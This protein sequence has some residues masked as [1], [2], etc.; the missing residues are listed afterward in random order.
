MIG[1]ATPL[2]AFATQAPLRS[3]ARLLVLASW[4]A[5]LGFYNMVSG[6]E[7]RAGALIE[8]IGV[9][10]QVNDLRLQCERSR[11]NWTYLLTIKSAEDSERVFATSP[12]IFLRSSLRQH[13]RAQDNQPSRESKIETISRK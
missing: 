9:V 6:D 10:F 1:H 12:I 13:T 3:A 2:P 7:C 4:R 8:S 11:Q 5:A